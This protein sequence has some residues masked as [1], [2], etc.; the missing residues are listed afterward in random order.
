MKKNSYVHLIGT[1]QEKTCSVNTYHIIVNLHYIE[2]K[3][4]GDPFWAAIL[5]FKPTLMQTN[6]DDA[7]PEMEN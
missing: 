7:T 2:I 6:V 3:K 5:G 1:T 4:D